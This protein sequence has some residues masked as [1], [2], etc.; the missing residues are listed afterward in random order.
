[1]KKI[2]YILFAA[3]LISACDKSPEITDDILDGDVIFDP[4]IYNPADYLISKSLPNPTAEEASKPVII[5]GHGYTASTFEWDE[6]R[7][8]MGN[9]TDFYMSQVLLGGHGLD[10]ESFKNASWKNWQSS[11]IEEYIALENAGFTDIS[12]AGSSTSCTLILELVASGFFD[13]HIKPQNIF[14]IDPLIISS[15]KTIS[16]VGVLG[17]MLGYL[18]TDL[19]DEENSVWYRF[20]PYETLKE[21]NEI[22]VK[23][24]KD[25]ED[26]IT[27]PHNCYLKVY[28]SKTDEVT[29]PYG[30]VL[31]YKGTKTSEGKN[32]DA[33]IIDSEY[34]V[35]TRLDLRE[36]VTEKDL[37]NQANTFI[38]MTNKLLDY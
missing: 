15:N 24:R 35:Y 12:F 17:P 28:K 9:R 6:Y 27:L 25:L 33:E 30:A 2:I 18:E 7:E 23:V 4:S 8:W 36:N 16:V 38:E 1:M 20:R 31:I 13:N 32:I 5:C 26:G 14:L 29:D 34:H 3:L 22:M 11:I 10:Y 19:T 21:L 37:Q